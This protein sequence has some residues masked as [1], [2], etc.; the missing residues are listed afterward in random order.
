M[1]DPPDESNDLDVNVHTSAGRIDVTDWYSTTGSGAGRLESR[2]VKEGSSGT[3]VLLHKWVYTSHTA[4]TGNEA[5][6]I[7]P[8]SKEIQYT[9]DSGSGDP[10]T[11]EYTY[12]WHVNSS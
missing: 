4:G 2:A 7:Y 12:T 11:T 9:S 6:T 1:T 8:V 5:H 10:V 3:A